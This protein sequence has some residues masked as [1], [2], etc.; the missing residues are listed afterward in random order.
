MRRFLQFNIPF[1][2]DF[3]MQN[4]EHWLV[5]IKDAVWGIPL[6]LFLI[7]TGAWL[8]WLLKGIQFRYLGYAFKQIFIKPADSKGDI[9][10]YEALM[11]SLAGAIG[12]GSIVGVSTAV[13]IGGLGALF[14]MW[15]TAFFG[16]ATKYAESL[17]AIKYR[18]IDDRGEMIGGPMEYIQR[19]L[20]WKWMAILFAILGSIAAIGTGNL[21]QVN[22]IAEA[23]N[24][25]WSVDIWMT[26]IVLAIV[27]FMVIVGGV[28][29]IGHVAGIL[30]PFMALFYMVGGFIILG[31][32]YT[33]IPHAFE[34][35][36]K[37]AFN[38]AAAAGG[39]AG[40]SLLLVIQLGVSRSVFSNEAGLGI[41]SIAAA[42]ARTDSPGRQAMITMTG[43]LIS[44]MVICTITGLVL[45]VTG[46]IGMTGADGAIL[47]GAPLAIKAFSSSLWG[48][49]YIVT[50]G[51]ILFAY[52]TVL[53]WAYYGE[54]CFEY[55]LGERSII[56]Y[57]IIYCLL[58][59]PGTAL[60]ME[61]VWQLADITNGLMVI[62]NLI[63]LIM[64]SKVIRDETASFLV[65]VK[66][67]ESL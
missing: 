34:L 18:E 10:P 3:F 47:N 5:Q 21:V 66:K 62:P 32:H 23:I 53:A 15:V 42:A 56:W 11:T 55:L 28:K 20:G 54:K 33:E 41:S 36:F 1:E 2:Y 61:T 52:S 48:G 57:R 14:W 29:S 25:V 22:S 44:T 26:G 27:T 65:Q 19:G 7:G 35:I 50:I 45:A 12:T 30:V 58:I 60:K 64:L 37:G 31:K 67:E 17:L 46:V 63:A 51:L 39:I 13:A 16:M 49:D 38:G 8:T 4:F 40:G 6:L 24:E 43:A 59:I 9:N